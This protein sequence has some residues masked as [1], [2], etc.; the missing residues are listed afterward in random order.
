MKK[1]PPSAEAIFS[2]EKIKLTLVLTLVLAFIPWEAADF[3]ASFGATEMTAKTRLRTT[4]EPGDARIIRAFEKAKH[5]CQAEAGLLT[6]VNPQ[7]QTRDALLTI[8]AKTKA[9]V[10]ADLNAMTEAIT[11]AFAKDG[12]TDLFVIDRNPYA[13]PVPNDTMSLLHKICHWMGILFLIGGLGL[14]FKQWK[15]LT[16]PPAATFALLGTLAFFTLLFMGER[17]ASIWLLLF[18]L[19]VPGLIL[20]LVSRMTWKV[21]KAKS[22][23]ETSARIL[24]SKVEVERHRFGGDTTKVTN[25]AYVTY[26]FK[27]GTQTVQG[28]TISIGDAPADRVDE[29]LKKYPVGANVPVFYDPANPPDCVLERDPPASLGCIWTGAGLF[30]LVYALVV[31]FFWNGY[32]INSTLE[33]AL[34]KIHHPLIAIGCGLFCL[35]CLASAIWNRLHQRKAFPWARTQG[36]IVS[37]ETESYTDSVGNHQTRFYKAVIEFNYQVE[38]QEYH[39]TIGESSGSQSSADAEV[40]RYPA[41]LK[42]E[43]YY[44]P[45]NPTHSALNV[46]TEMMLDGVRSFIVAMIFFAIAYLAARG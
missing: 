21:R 20:V 3:V 34:P 28:D 6:E 25:K 12:G 9:E 22:W 39:N 30:I 18:I 43:V 45:K 7:Q 27:V 32:S 5:V 42:V 11:A 1:E 44:D 35:L 2:V 46:D 36:A 8:K 24:E 13:T 37:S 14:V 41:G 31:L 38:G 23:L 29:T 16:L 17:S 26:E 40:A 33:V 15:S 19:F 4:Q 10:L